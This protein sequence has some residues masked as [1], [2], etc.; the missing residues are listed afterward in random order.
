MSRFSI[1]F[2]VQREFTLGE[3]QPADESAD[4]VGIDFVLRPDG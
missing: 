3:G 4:D 2:P 1:P